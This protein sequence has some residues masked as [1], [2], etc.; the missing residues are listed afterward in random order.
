M[1]KAKQRNMGAASQQAKIMVVSDALKQISG[2]LEELKDSP[3]LS[4][5]V[6][7][8]LKQTLD[9]PSDVF[10]IR[11][12]QLEETAVNTRRSM[13]EILRRIA[14]EKDCE[15]EF[16]PPHGN[17][18]CVR[19]FEQ[20][21]NTWRLSVLDDVP[22]TIIE[23]VNGEML[24]NAAVEIIL[25]IENV[26]AK[27]KTYAKPLETAYRTLQTSTQ[28][29]FASPPTTALGPIDFLYF[30]VGMSLSDWHEGS[31]LDIRLYDGRN[32]LSASSLLSFGSYR[33]ERSLWPGTTIEFKTLVNGSICGEYEI[34]PFFVR[35][36]I[37][38]SVFMSAPY[39]KTGFAVSG[40]F[41]QGQTATIISCRVVA[42]E[43]ILVGNFEGGEAG[44]CG[45]N[46]I[47]P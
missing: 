47:R 24:A 38:S 32:L 30:E 1:A 29:Q 33:S 41:Y 13:G 27:A 6:F 9:L 10:A 14:T 19:F 3:A 8:L 28:F 2:A 35:P 5:E 39:P 40:G 26:I 15:V 37:F 11:Q 23:T 46:L 34:V 4:K 31:Y 7:A 18:G 42:A 20:Q 22:I 16:R 43:E 44:T 36:T 17:F 25:S 12:T 45:K 21:P